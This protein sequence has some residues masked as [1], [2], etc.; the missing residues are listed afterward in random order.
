MGKKVYNITGFDCANC[1]ANAEAHLNKNEKVNAARI[2]FMGSRL[3]LTSEKKDLTI[4]EIKAIIAEVEDDPIEITEIDNR[5]AKKTKIF[6]KHTLFL[7]FRVLYCVVVI[8]VSGF[9]LKDFYWVR[10]GLYISALVVIEY[11]IVFKVVHK[12][13]HLQ[14]PV[15]EYLLIV[16]A[17]VGAFVLASIKYANDGEA[18]MLKA[19][20][21]FFIEE[22]CESL[23]V[24]MLWQIGQII[25]SVAVSKS[26]EAVISAVDLRNDDAYVEQDGEIVKVAAQDVNIGDVIVVK[27]GETIA[28]DGEV[29]SGN[30]YLDVSSITGEP[31]PIAI[32]EKSDVFSGA[33]LKEGSIKFKATKKYEDSTAN[34]ILTLVQESGEKKSN[35][36]KFITRFARFYTPIICLIAIAY[37][38]IAGLVTQNWPQS[39]YTGL[40]ILVISCPCAIV[41]SVPLAYF[42]AIGLSSKNSIIVKGTN[43]FDS[44]NRLKKVVVDKT[45]TLTHGAFEIKSVVPAEGID[46]KDLLDAL[47]IGE[48]LSEHPIAKTICH[49]YNLKKLRAEQSNFMEFPGFGNE[50]TYQNDLYFVGNSK[51]MEKHGLL[52]Q[53]PNEL[54]TVVHAGKNDQYL[55][56]IV[57]ADRLKEDAQP[58]VDLLHHD[59]IKLVLLT[60]DKEDNAKNICNYLGI[61][62]WH[63]NLLPGDKVTYLEMEMNNTKGTV[64]FVGDGINDAPVIKRSDVGVAMGALGSDAAVENA[65]IVIMNDDPAKMYDVYKISKMA[66][67]TAIF[68]IIFA[69]LVKAAVLV[70]AFIFKD[71]LPMEVAVFADTGVTVILVVNSLLL[72]YRKVKRPKLQ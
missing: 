24:V 68:N 67:N 14:N 69:L 5:K 65:D 71:K 52:V 29:I 36:D 6:D 66:R 46:E 37:I 21:V 59:D 39:V 17:T 13:I 57:L 49:G 60:G 4:E 62:E 55:G 41:I 10:F 61:D 15:D 56:Y 25:E 42:S 33:L 35:A 31:L 50:T 28:V 40:D 45:G 34:R 54:G 16:L 48:C 51:L 11:D 72:L 30:G 12:I 2:D 20:E 43:H 1:A 9:F 26:R 22:H 58:M 19:G 38:V 63:S 70:L 7:L 3:Y 32:E 53:N 23:F 27:A 47:H 8:L 64:A 18:Y 44:L